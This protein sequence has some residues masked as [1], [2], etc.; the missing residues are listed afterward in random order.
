MNTT[1]LLL[2]G[3]LAQ[4]ATCVKLGVGCVLTDSNG[5]ILSA[6]YNGVPSGWEHCDK[7]TKCHPFHCYATH[8]ESNAIISCHAPKSAIDACYVT[9][10]P[11]IACCKQLIQTGCDQIIFLHKSEEHD[12]SR[13]FWRQ[14]G[15][16]V[17][18]QHTDMANVHELLHNLCNTVAR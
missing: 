4:R 1:M 18:V 15:Q 10:S 14:A 9:Y 13:D 11:C 3:L 2:A 17:W 6:G 16:R 5:R 7:K 12:M 8:A